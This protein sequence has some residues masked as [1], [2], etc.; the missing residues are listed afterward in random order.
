MEPKMDDVF[1]IS[2]EILPR[3]YVDRGA[4]DAQI[5][6]L[7]SKN[8]HIALRGESKCGKT[9]L[10][11]K[12]IPDAIVVQC[13]LTKKAVDIY[14]DALSQLDIKFTVESSTSN[15]FRGHIEASGSLGVEILGELGIKFGAE[16]QD[17][18]GSKRENVG[19]DI[20]DLRYIADIFREANR[21]IVV[22][23]FHY[24]SILERRVFSFDLKA[25][26]D[27]GVY[28]VIIGVWNRDNLLTTLNPDLTGRFEEISIYW[29]KED[30]GRVL[31]KGGEALNIEFCDE[32]IG[33]LADDCF[34][35]VGILQKI[36]SVCLE[37][38]SIYVRCSSLTHFCDLEKIEDA[39]IFYAE[40]LE[41]LYRQFAERLSSGIRKRKQATAIYSHAMAAILE[42]DKSELI[43]GIHIDNIFSISNSRQPRIQKGNLRSVLEKMDELQVDTEGRGLVISYN[44]G[45]KKVIVIDRQLLLF[46]KY[47]TIDWPWEEMIKEAEASKQEY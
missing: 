46:L 39:A 29:T 41:S 44:P 11:K 4:L 30:L 2:T 10:R 23:D 20:N 21:R 26:W 18:S 35:N 6:R 12:N 32:F 15:Q 13:R 40:Q 25:L 33:K 7:L 16:T 5:S 28:I 37:K 43:N 31:K 38:S 9:W 34:G 27:Y 45:S 42:S 1:G 3:S 14:V 47:K 22:E 17:A 19:K 24:M 36:I 8:T